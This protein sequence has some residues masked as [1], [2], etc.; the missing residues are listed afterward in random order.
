MLKKIKINCS[1]ETSLRGK[2]TEIFPD[3]LL[4]PYLTLLRGFSNKKKKFGE[5]KKINYLIIKMR[6]HNAILNYVSQQFHVLDFSDFDQHWRSYNC[7][8]SLT[9]GYRQSKVLKQN[10][11]FYSWHGAAAWNEPA[12]CLNRRGFHSEMHLTG[13]INQFV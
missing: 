10:M 3:F 11:G 4:N 7:K 9:E 13:I 5:K 8:L 1:W 12:E 2:L 6:R